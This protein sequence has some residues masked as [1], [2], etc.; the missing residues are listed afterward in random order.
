MLRPPVQR[1]LVSRLGAVLRHSLLLAA[2]LAACAALAPAAQAQY[3]GRNQVRYDDFDYQVL[4]TEH[5]DIYYYAGMEQSVHDVA[6]MAER[7]YSAPLDRLWARV[8]PSVS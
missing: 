8:R 1:P 7:W 5:F 6:R 4:Q 2:A 3:F